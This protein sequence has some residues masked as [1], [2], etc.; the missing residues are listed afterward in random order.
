MWGEMHVKVLVSPVSLDEAKV[1]VA[2]GADIL[3]VKNTNEGSLGAQFPWVIREVA[4]YASGSNIVVSATIG[5]LDFKPGTAAQAAFG[6]ATAGARY[7]KAGLYNVSAVA[8]A[9][10]IMNA[11][12]HACDMVDPQ[13]QVV[14]A[15]YAD[16]ERFGGLSPLEIVEAASLTACNVVMLDTAIKDGKTLLDN[17]S[18]AEIRTFIEAGHAS[19]MLVALAGSISQ[20]HLEPLASVGTDIVGIRG[21]VCDAADRKRGI[22]QSKVEAFM[23]QARQYAHAI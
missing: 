18:L 20:E 22:I 23:A 19:G 21:A 5:D 15:G 3:D 14:A 8:Q 7:I 13:I 17:L 10:A 1:V 16:Y 2:G 6:A 12:R 11:V 9:V 4:Q